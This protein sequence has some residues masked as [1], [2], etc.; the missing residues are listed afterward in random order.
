MRTALLWL[1]LIVG[2]AHGNTFD[3]LLAQAEEGDAQAQAEVGQALLTGNGV[4][5]DESA[6]LEWIE[7]AAAEENAR[8]LFLLATLISVGA[9]PERPADEAIPLLKRAAELGDGFAQ[10]DY[11]TG[12]LEG[13]VP[14][15]TLRQ[16]VRFVRLAAE[17]GVI[18]AQR[19]LGLYYG[20]GSPHF[21]VDHI[22]SMRWFTAAAEQGDAIAQVNLARMLQF[23]RGEIEP[24]AARALELY[25][26]AA[27]QGQREA[28]SSL[29]MIF[30]RGEDVPRDILRGAE[31]LEAAAWQGESE[32][33]W[34]IGQL[35]APGGIEAIQDPSAA[36]FWLYLAQMNSYPEASESLAAVAPLLSEEARAT[37]EATAT[38][39]HP[40]MVHGNR[41]SSG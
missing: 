26:A 32:A 6:A 39:L 8:G 5:K 13:E 9:H 31:L 1:L 28:Q 17:G 11:G 22:Q 20:G 21:P 33:Q 36:Y 16:G 38:E 40:A 10:L 29:G 3:E 41:P 27:T 23:G 25:E 37:I 18:E 15:V 12:I 14:A 24:N 4:E 35:Y 2:M 19:N 7:R 30:L 34:A